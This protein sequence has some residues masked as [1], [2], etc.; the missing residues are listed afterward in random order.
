MKEK[1]TLWNRF[2]EDIC[3]RDAATLSADNYPGQSPVAKRTNLKRPT[4]P[5]T[6][7]CH[8]YASVRRNSYGKT[9]LLFLTEG[10]V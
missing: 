1:D 4:M 10:A 9:E 6:I 3:D 8:R 5:V 7:L 2:I